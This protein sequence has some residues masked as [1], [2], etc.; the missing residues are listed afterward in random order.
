LRDP[1]SAGVAQ[2]ELARTVANI[3][4]VDSTV[5]L[6]FT[7]RKEMSNSI[8]IRGPKAMFTG[9]CALGPACFDFASDAD[10]DLLDAAS[11]Q[12]NR[13]PH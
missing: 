3:G 12:R 8:V 1:R 2:T 13:P 6:D 5:A 10:L 7:P 9:A 11:T 4:C